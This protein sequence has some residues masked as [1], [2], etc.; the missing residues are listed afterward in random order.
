MW[1]KAHCKRYG[2]VWLTEGRFSLSL[3]QKELVGARVSLGHAVAAKASLD[4]D[5]PTQSSWQVKTDGFG[6]EGGKKT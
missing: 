2:P 6:Q 1:R 3:R 4:F 5:L